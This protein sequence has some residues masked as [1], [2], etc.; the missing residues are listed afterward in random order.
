MKPRRPA[1]GSP[2]VPPSKPAPK[3]QPAP[4]AAAATSPASAASATWAAPAATT[5]PTPAATASFAAHAA[6][7]PATDL[8]GASHG[9]TS[10]TQVSSPFNAEEKVTL[11]KKIPCPALA[12]M[13]NA[14]MLKTEKDGTVKIPDLERALSQ[15]GPNA[16]TRKILTNGADATDSVK[17]SFNLFTLNGSNLDHSGST[18]I[19]Q[20]GVHPERFDVLMSFSTDGERLTAKDLANAGEHF[21]KED[22]GL[23]GRV[24]QLAEFSI[25]MEVFGRRAADGSRYFTKEDAKQLFVDGQIPSSWQ[26]PAV[27]GKVGLTD[28]LGGTALGLFRQL[29]NGR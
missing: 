14:G 18:G 21:A 13:F 29:V 16:I 15:L 8:E 22:P 6:A 4:A 19:R 5:S 7:A 24:T 1:D 26:P 2:V 20:N 17:G 10:P 11:S 9:Y 28:V 12:G 3:A 27:P 23:R 25:V